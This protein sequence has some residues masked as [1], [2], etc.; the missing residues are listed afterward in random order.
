[1]KLT[2]RSEIDGLRGLSVLGVLLFHL[3]FEL[4]SG[5]YLGVDVFIVI[6]GYLITS[7]IFDNLKLE[8]FNFKVFFLRRA[9]RLLPSY[10]VVL[11]IS[12]F[13]SYLFLLPE[14]LLKFSKSLLSSTFFVSNFFFWLTSGYWEEG[15][16]NPLLHTWSLSLEWQFYF[17]L[18]VFSYLTWKFSKVVFKNQ[19]IFILIFAI[20]FSLAILFIDRNVS[21]FLLPFRLYEFLIGS[22]IYFL[23]DKDFKIISNYKNF[24]S[25]VA[26]GL[27][28]S[29]FVLFDSLTQVP[30]YIALIPC[31]GC[32]L[33]ILIKDSFIHKLLRAKYLVFIGLIS[34]SLYL[35]HWPI[36]T[37]YNTISIYENNYIDKILLA[38]ISIFISIINY[39]LIEK[40]F[41]KNSFFSK[42]ANINLFIPVFLIT[43]F[44]SFLVINKDG[45]P[46]RISSKKNSLV[47]GIKLNEKNVRSEFI[48]NNVNLKFSTN[49]N[50]KILILGDSL[51]EDL[52]LALK[53]NLNDKEFDIEYLNFNHWCFEK[54]KIINLFSF[55][56]RIGSRLS[57]C[58]KE[59]KRF[60]QN[61]DLIN[62][63][64]YI[65]LSCSW[66]NNFLNYIEDIVN[67]IKKY[68]DT[69]IIVSSKNVLFPDIPNLVKNIDKKDLNNL[70][71]IA[72][73]VKYKSTYKF[74]KKL[75]K[76]VNLL[77]LK[78]LDKTKL[79][80]SDKEKKCNVYD[81]KNKELYIFDNHHW[82]FNGAKFFGSMINISGL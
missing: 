39:L 12:L 68:N 50:V 30:G 21:F 14:D 55:I 71:E 73:K 13:F 65:I 29:S 66:H 56:D 64:N 44:L 31:I 75:E 25:F 77:D 16:F 36:I 53:Q 19:I 79:I 49:N 20:S 18:S 38:L 17:F 43:I 32:A 28:L 40:P 9:K 47:D 34:Y 42:F 11:L 81:K 6:S 41:R 60:D 10:F 26:L 48:K 23:I 82:T 74:N 15:G 2:Y 24:L 7:I 46:E 35:F 67:F 57:F 61:S 37:F 8:K 22:F 51:G 33:L 76:A 5:G 63:A 45:Y 59:K 80:C 69:K 4:F 70:N 27:I 52:F 3:K 78:Y 54:N 1:M 58:E 62:K 72:Y